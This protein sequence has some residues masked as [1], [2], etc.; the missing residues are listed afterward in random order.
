MLTPRSE[1]GHE[2]APV[3]KPLLDFA[4]MRHGSAIVAA[5]C[6]A[7]DCR[8]VPMISPRRPSSV[9]RCRQHHRPAIPALAAAED[10]ATL[11]T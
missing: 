4:S 2:H 8:L 6:I 7:I 11:L 9:A 1:A 10:L 3:E 5:S